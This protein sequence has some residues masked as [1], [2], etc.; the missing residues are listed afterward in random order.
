MKSKKDA[1]KIIE[2]LKDFY[3]DATCSLDF[4]SPFEMMVSVMLAAQCTDER[5][6]KTTPNLFNKYNTPEAI[7]KM[8]LKELE[9]I[10][11]PC[12]F[13]KTKAKNLKAC[14]QKL[15]DEFDGK[16]PQNMKDLQS[17]PGVGRKSANVVMLEAFHDPQG[18]AVDTHAK[19]ISN[20][21]GFSSQ[22]EPEKIEQ[23]LLKQIPKEY[24]YDVNHLLVWHGRKICDARK[25]KCEECPV[26]NYCDEYN[27]M[28]KA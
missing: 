5:V 16:V 8:D 7:A 23:D 24:Y 4:K 11:H 25:P 12:G 2:I 17:L 20:R 22:A 13:Y 27:K 21:M 1:I 28:N 15:L 9:E 19:R 18:I 14:S 3:P 6:N 26:K 10:I